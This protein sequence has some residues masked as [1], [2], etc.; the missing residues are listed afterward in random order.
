MAKEAK[1]PCKFHQHVVGKIPRGLQTDE[2]MSA[3]IY[4]L[5]C[6]LLSMKKAMSNVDVAAMAKEL[7]EMLVGGFV[8]KAY[9]LSPDKVVISLQIPAQDLE[10]GP[11]E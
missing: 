1:P 9:Q 3:T 7:R 10:Q 8:G 6:H 5:T 11:A 2:K 4:R